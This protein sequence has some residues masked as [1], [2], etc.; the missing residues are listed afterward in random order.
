MRRLPVTAL[1][2]TL[3]ISDSVA[4]RCST[5]RFRGSDPFNPGILNRALPWTTA[6][7]VSIKKPPSSFA[8]GST[9]VHDSFI[10][11]SAVFESD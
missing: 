10:S 5:A 6:C 2:E 8:V 7:T 4:K 9:G 3:R 1:A 11:A